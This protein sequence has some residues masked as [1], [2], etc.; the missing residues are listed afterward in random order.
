M[1]RVRRVGR[2]A[3]ALLVVTLG[4][5]AV[6]LIVVSAGSRA[7]RITPLAPPPA[8]T[9][10]RAVEALNSRRDAEGSTWTPDRYA[11]G[12]SIVAADVPIAHTLAPE[13]Y[14]SQ[15]VGIR[16]LS[17]PVRSNG[18]YL[19]DLYFAEL[20]DAT[21]GSRVFEVS[22][23]GRPVARVDVAGAV[24]ALVPYHLPFTVTV[25]DRRLVIAFTAIQGRPILNAF[26]LQ[27][28]APSVDVPG[29]R[30]RWN[31]EFT[32][33]AGA[34]PDRK[35]WTFDLGTGWKQAADYTSHNAALDGN[36]DLVISAL[37]NGSRGG[38]YTSARLT[39]AGH[40]SFGYGTAEIRARVVD[41]PGFVTAFWGVGSDAVTVPWPRSGEIDAFEVRGQQPALLVEGLHMPCGTVDCPKS[42]EVPQPRSLAAGFHTYAL[43]H[44]P[45]VVVFSVDG[46]QSAS[47]TAADV[48][49]GSWVFDQNFDLIMNLLVGGWAGLPGVH[50]RWPVS[51]SIDWVRVFG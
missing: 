47:L 19:V 12:G 41:Q 21:A 22:A 4:I 32:G 5:A 26:S 24:G 48:R 29:Q 39:T 51:A 2:T 28:V 49:R 36:G 30:L 50:T 31:D 6:A 25:T 40:V 7:R 23:Q 34:A 10:L 18:T 15:R 35:H 16:T 33:P 20:T 1:T 44:A 37:D 13:L 46:V 42:W 8:V 9:T 38:T 17:V 11:Q 3:V 27:P 43:E 45:G 14:R